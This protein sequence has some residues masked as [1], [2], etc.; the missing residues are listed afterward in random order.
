MMEPSWQAQW[1]WSEGEISPRNEWRCFR[2]TFEMPE[3]GWEDASL[4]ITADSRYVLT[5]NGQQVG[6]GPVRSWP[7]EQSYDTYDI[8]HLLIKGKS[9]TIAVF[10]NHFGLS[11]FN[12]LRG[13]GA[14]L[15]QLDLALDGHS[16]PLVITD[17]TWLTSKYLGHH[18]R[19]PRMSCQQGY[20]EFVDASIWDSSWVFADYDDS[21]WEQ[22]TLV[23]PVGIE[24]WTTLKKRDIPF[25][26]EETKYPVR[27]ESLKQV[28]S[29]TWT[30]AIDF[31]NHMVS[32]SEEHMNVVGFTG[33]MATILNSAQSAS[34]ILGFTHSNEC[35]GRCTL[36]GKT[37]PPES[38]YGVQPEKYVQVQLEQG[39]NLFLIDVT[40]GGVHAGKLHFGIYSD[41]AVEV[42]SPLPLENQSSAFITIGPFDTAVFIDHQEK[43]FLDLDNEIYKSVLDEVKSVED[44]KRF[45]A[46]LKPVADTLVSEADVISLCIWKQESIA[47]NVPAELH[48]MVI[49]HQHP[50]VVPVFPGY[51]TEMVIDFDKEYSGYLAFDVEAEAG[52]II[53]LYG[54]EYMRDDY[55][56]DTFGLDNTLRYICKNG[57]QQYLSPIRRG[58]RYL[59][60]TVRNATAPVKIYG[61]TIAQ[62]NYPVAEVGSFHS[63][64][65]LLNDIWKISEHTTRLCMEDTFVDCPAFEQVFWVGDSR[66][67]ALVSN[68]LYGVNDIVKRCLRLVPGS[69]DQTPLYADQVPSGWSSVIPNWTFF[70]AIACYE[71][72]QQTGDRAF[73]QEMYPHIKFTLE[74]YQQKINADGLLEI[75]GWNLLDWSPIDQPNEG[76]V[77]HQN[78]FLV[79]TF[80]VAAE[81]ATIAGDDAGGKAF[82]EAGASL[83]QAINKHLWNP[84]KQAYIDCI[85]TDG[86]RSDIYS[87]HSQVV[88]NLTGVAGVEQ[89]QLIEQY[90]LNAP[91][92]FVQIG[93]P[94]MSFFYYETLAAAGKSQAIIEDIR[95]NYGQMIEHGATTCWEMYPNFAENRS[96]PDMLTR[97]H[98][99]AWSAAPAYFLGTE[100]L[101]IQRSAPGWE[102]VTIA[103]NP[104]GLTWA[105]GTVPHPEQGRIDVS[106]TADEANKRITIKVKHPKH[107]EVNVVV[108]EGYQGEVVVAVI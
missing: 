93:S 81:M 75:K 69:K 100:V 79:K 3:T 66:N 108:P 58:L 25:L 95:K 44:L 28:K 26:T 35:V 27:V 91:A 8:K 98:C 46:Y 103:P 62:S 48:N 88:A 15:A 23:G 1:I 99:H 61:V 19:A 10:V 74:H 34:V 40:A 51:D 21:S 14:L 24:P 77:T 102:K 106:W 104:C 56:Q 60:V 54:F 30:T 72:Y 16:T 2:K 39:D 20:S 59:M 94:F 22:A 13:R 68:Y 9:N 32:G 80:L 38:F 42:K 71:Y 107:V 41:S 70:W 67:E 86:R 57:R 82:T 96:N 52:T 29:F 50:A 92:D 97:S 83:K 4:R 65:A 36:N 6:R 11:T 64:D 33:Y 90:L 85:H 43:V 31:R 84:E 45:Q 12:Y 78:M 5:V 105:R 18:S 76:V 17:D 55:R 7:F 89:K 73:A 101:G 63:S 49:P 87:M 47:H 37:I 53:D